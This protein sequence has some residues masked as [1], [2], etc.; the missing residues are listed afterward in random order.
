MTKEVCS[1]G[2][3]YDRGYTEN[4]NL[5]FPDRFTKF[6]TGQEDDGLPVQRPAYD[7]IDLRPDDR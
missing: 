4:N 7:Q 6:T 5:S 1:H 2:L 3:I